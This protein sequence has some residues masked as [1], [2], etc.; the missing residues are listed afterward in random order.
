M[1]WEEA[2][3]PLFQYNMRHIRLRALLA[4]VGLLASSSAANAQVFSNPLNTLAID[5]GA[6]SD[7]NQFLA[8]RFNLLSGST[9]NFASWFGTLSNAQANTGDHWNF[10]VVFRAGGPTPGAVLAT[11]NVSATVLSTNT[12]V[13]GEREYQFST[14]FAGVSLLG[15]T[16]YFFSAINTGTANT[17][18]WTQGTKT[19]YDAYFSFGGPFTQIDESYR[20]P[21]NFEL[22]DSP[23]T[24][25]TPEPATFVLFGAGLTVMFGVRRRIRQ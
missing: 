24:T 11:R 25:V 2:K 12:L 20:S 5:P 18:R 14:S 21:L 17:F 7:P 23:V 22:Y 9:V 8:G 3:N 6:Y 15:A 16:D 10:D 4:A 1:Y 19:Q 13:T